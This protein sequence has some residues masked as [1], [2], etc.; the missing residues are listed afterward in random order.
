MKKGI[1]FLI[2]LLCM[3][4][5]ASAYAA[6]T[7]PTSANVKT[8]NDKFDELRESS[9]G[10]VGYIHNE[11]GSGYRYHFNEEGELYL[12]VW[13]CIDDAN[14]EYF[15]THFNAD[16]SFQNR[17]ESQYLDDDFKMWLVVLKDEQGNVTHRSV[18]VNDNSTRQSYSYDAE[19]NTFF[20]DREEVDADSVPAV[21]RAA[22]VSGETPTSNNTGST[23]NVAAE[24]APPIGEPEKELKGP[25]F[26]DGEWKEDTKG[27]WFAYPDGTYA[28][29]GWAKINGLW[30][31]FDKDGYMKK[32]AWEGD[33]YLTKEGPMAVSAWI[34]GYYVDETGKWVPDK[35]AWEQDEKGWK[36]QDV[37]SA[38]KQISGKWYY[39]D[40]DGYMVTNTIV[41]G[42]TIGADGVWVK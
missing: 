1:V 6:P 38:W 5:V 11:D 22:L 42:Y 41:D 25:F 17:Q 20:V 13:E 32:N 36:Y 31:F 34:D 24:S 7:S 14:N 39:F 26:T 27:K 37:K 18:D 8:V 23:E 4:L 30:Y 9:S 12:I 40:A 16:G 19:T 15:F 3:M 33:Y 21:I 28:R 29:N 2:A 35:K 10:K